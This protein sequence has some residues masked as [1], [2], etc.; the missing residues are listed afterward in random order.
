MYQSGANSF[1][2]KARDRA[3][4]PLGGIRKRAFDITFTSIALI[5]LAPILFTTAGL[6]R[7]LIRKSI[8]VRDECIGF[9]GKPFIR[10]QFAFSVDERVDTSSALLRL[11]DPSWAESLEDALRASGL[12]KL[13]LLFNV[14]QG[15]MSL[16]GPRPI[17]VRQLSHY[18]GLMPEYLLARPGVTGVWRRTRKTR[19][20]IALDRYY[21]RYWSVR[22][23]LG[24]LAEAISR[25][26]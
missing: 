8:I 2:A 4:A 26:G 24:L 19:R 12:D 3:R 23:D 9:G 5:V 1:S 11:N 7:L 21:A 18:N 20:A 10:Y 6:V 22:L 14:L 17:T 16:I 13:P 15:D 25:V